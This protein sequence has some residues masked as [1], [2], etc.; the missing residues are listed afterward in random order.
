MPLRK[1]VFAVVFR[2]RTSQD[3]SWHGVYEFVASRILCVSVQGCF[4]IFLEV[5]EKLLSQ[6]DAL[7]KEISALRSALETKNTECFSEIK[8]IKEQIGA[9]DEKIAAKAKEE[10]KTKDAVNKQFEEIS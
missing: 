1:C 4:S 8:A 3:V 2:P 6:S 7:K 10:E 9:V 5:S